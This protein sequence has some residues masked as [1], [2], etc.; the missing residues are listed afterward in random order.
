MLKINATIP[1]I[2]ATISEND[3]QTLKIDATIPGNDSHIP[4]IKA[5]I[6][7][8]D[9]QALKINATIPG[10]DSQML[11]TVLVLQKIIPICLELRPPQCHS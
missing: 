5:T 8:N 10:N 3:S 6:P 7:K 4:K 11:W 1:K 2:D 9:S